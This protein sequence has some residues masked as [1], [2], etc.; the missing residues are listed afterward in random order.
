MLQLSGVRAHYGVIRALDGVDLE[1]REGEIVAVIGANGAGKS[2]ILMS[3]CGIVP[4]SAGVI[5]FRG[6]R[7]DGL[8]AER[9]VPLGISQVPE[10]RKI[11]SRL[12]VAE[13]LRLGAFVRK[14]KE[15]AAD[16]EKML[17]LFPI[18]ARRKAQAA[19]TLSGGEQQMLAIARAL[20]ARP[21]LLLLD[22]PSLGL[23]P[24][25][26]KKIFETLQDLNR[27]GT[28]V[29]LVEQNAHQALSIAHRGYV[30]ES[31]AVVMSG[32]ASDL[33]EDDK[34]RRAYLGY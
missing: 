11:F 26:I 20:M 13:N 5:T 8:E 22:E 31:G 6:E 15:V 33:L 12:T 7:I 1:I 29:M 18:L 25:I 3:I 21:A 32:K 17:A 9:I 28:T 4:V 34:I 10:G 27:S 23:A 14:D 30:M 24:L 2:T 16:M 19:G